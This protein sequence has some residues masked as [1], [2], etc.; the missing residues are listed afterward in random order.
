MGE[1][2]WKIA[3]AGGAVVPDLGSR[4]GW[5]AELARAGVGLSPNWGGF[6][7][8]GPAPTTGWLHPLARPVHA[9][10]IAASVAAAGGGGA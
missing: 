6:R 9:A 5:R 1:H 8:K 3:E 10:N 7:E 4:N 2:L